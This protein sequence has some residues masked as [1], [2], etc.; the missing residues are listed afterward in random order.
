[1]HI[2]EYVRLEA[3]VEGSLSY[4]RFFGPETLPPSP[5]D[6]VA[7]PV[8]SDINEVN[9]LN[10]PEREEQRRKNREIIDR[11][12]RALAIERGEIVDDGE[13]GVGVPPPPPA[14]EVGKGRGVEV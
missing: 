5:E 4:S 10:G 11:H 13:G 9:R 6:R 1:M 14:Y 12:V 8:E 2:D 7:R 3:F